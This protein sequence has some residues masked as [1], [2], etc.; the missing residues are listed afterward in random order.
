MRILWVATKPPWPPVDGG[1]LVSAL[2]IEA[3]HAAGH[4]GTLVSPIDPRAGDR[5][6]VEA[7]LTRWCRPFLVPA[8]PA[9]LLRAGMRSA[10][11][12]MPATIYRHA[13][14]A[15][16]RRVTRLA[17]RESFDIAHA[18]QV[19]AL[20]QCDGLGVP[21]VLRAQN[22]ESD[23]WHGAA[24]RAGLFGRWLRREA[25]R[26]AAWEGAAVRRTASTVALTKRDAERLTLLSGAPAK[27]RVVPAPFPVRLPPAEEPLPGAPA[28]VVFGSAGWRPN[29]EGTT[30]F[31]RRVWPLVRAGCPGA[32]LHLFGGDAVGGDGVETKPAPSESREAF[33]PASILAVPLHLASGVRMKILEAWARGVPV[34]ATPEAAAGLAAAHE[35][36][37]LLASS[38]S[39]FAAAIRRLHAEPGLPVALVESGRRLLETVHAPGAVAAGLVEVYS[40]VRREST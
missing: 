7:R 5:A 10:L 38:A 26:L 3:L 12:R 31:L 36:E 19:Q 25:R 27:T 30:W 32:I 15:V 2:T 22:V 14:P 33:A 35:R 23:L 37:L 6:A 13:L 9:H 24:Q 16:R 21:V 1:R 18:E 17:F 20:A 28:V 39:E 4:E 8:A 11:G 40:S 34:V 29:R